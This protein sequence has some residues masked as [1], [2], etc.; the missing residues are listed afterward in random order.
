MVGNGCSRWRQSA[1][2]A[3]GQ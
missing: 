2:P 3:D 1:C